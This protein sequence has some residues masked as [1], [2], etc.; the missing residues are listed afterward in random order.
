MSTEDPFSIVVTDAV[1]TVVGDLDAHTSPRLDAVIADRGGAAPVVLDMGDVE[2]IDSSGLRS[3]LRARAEG[4]AE[5]VVI[6]RRPSAA[7][8]RLL[9]ITGLTEQFTIESA[10]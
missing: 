3:L 2:F 7:T 5:R 4:D 1:I 8:L 6:I 9:E 10:P